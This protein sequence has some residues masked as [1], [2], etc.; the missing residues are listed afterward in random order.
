MTRRRSR[1]EQRGADNSKAREELN[2]TPRYTSRKE[3]FGAE[4]ALQSESGPTATDDPLDQRKLG[5]NL[6]DL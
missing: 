3:G 5:Y 6:D 4:L 1:L 2:W